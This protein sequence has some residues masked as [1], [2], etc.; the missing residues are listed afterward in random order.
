MA[1]T[2]HFIA[3]LK[4]NPVSTASVDRY[5]A[6]LADGFSG[7]VP[8]HVRVAV[9]APSVYL[10]RFAERLPEGIVPAAQ[11]LFWESE[12]S[13]TGQ[14]TP[15]MLSDL[16][17][18][19][20]LIGHSERRSYGH[21]TDE[22]TGKKVVA[23]LSAGFLTVVC[24]GETAEERG[25]GSEAGVI[26]RQIAAALDGVRVTDAERIVIAYEPRWAIGT[27]RTPSSDEILEAGIIVR[28]ALAER[29]DP[30]T[31]G[32]IPVL[33]GGSV[34]HTLLDETC[35]RSGM[36]GVLVGRESLRPR[37]VA[38]MVG[39]MEVKSTEA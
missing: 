6:D 9:A 38:R 25:A 3:N 39:A 29:F 33:Y 12:G 19:M 13:Y 1:K 8:E 16:G 4:A 37:E 2:F 26:S 18:R 30:E 21:E 32:K 20:T 27:D 36:D 24:V 35:F 15:A 10:E 23:A 7:G 14:V 17:V 28:R 11:D 34:K 31:A 5:L 22:E